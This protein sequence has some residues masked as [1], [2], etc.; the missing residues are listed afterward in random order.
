MGVVVS[1]NRCERCGWG[2]PPESA[3]DD[4]VKTWCARF[5]EAKSKLFG[6]KWFAKNVTC[7][8]PSHLVFQERRRIDPR[9]AK[10]MLE[11]LREERPLLFDLFTSL[12]AVYRLADEVPPPI[13]CDDIAAAITEAEYRVF[14]YER[15]E[16]EAERHS[17]AAYNRFE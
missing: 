15:P 10:E 8:W 17:V 14:N 16:D 3:S 4:G 6:C 2:F 12:E 9:V 7:I 11:V 5:K 13:D 1:E